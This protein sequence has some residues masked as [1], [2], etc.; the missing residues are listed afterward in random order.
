MRI[1]K[2]SNYF[3]EDKMR[4]IIVL[5]MT[6]TLH[7]YLYGE[8]DSIWYFGFDIGYGEARMEANNMPLNT[9]YTNFINLK[10][11][12]GGVNFGVMAGLKRFYDYG[13]GYR[14][15]AS[16]SYQP[17][18]SNISGDAKA[19]LVNFGV[20]ADFLYNFI[21]NTNYDIGLFAGLGLGS[22]VYV[23]SSIDNLEDIAS[24]SSSSNLIMQSAIQFS[25]IHFDIWLN[26]GLRSIFYK[27]FGLE[28]GVRMPF[29]TNNIFSMNMASLGL[30]NV[31]SYT[32][33]I[34]N[35]YNVFGRV[36]FSF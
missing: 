27:Y 1:F 4:K 6:F 25:R 10:D 29:M 30:G 19:G 16:L 23:G 24:S 9:S 36:T 13:I 8:D 5:L 11:K 33:K 3:F 32:I 28:A 22:N 17:E 15:Y 14:L 20:N 2:S 18:F 12:G 21:N 26:A 34:K 31:P 7:S 35:N